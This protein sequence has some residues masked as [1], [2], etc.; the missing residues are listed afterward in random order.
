[1]NDVFGPASVRWAVANR[2]TRSLPATPRDASGCTRDAAAAGTSVRTGAE[3]GI[4]TWARAGV[5]PGF[6][7]AWASPRGMQMLSSGPSS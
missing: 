6:T 2:V 4:A 1:M 7:A 3:V 5:A